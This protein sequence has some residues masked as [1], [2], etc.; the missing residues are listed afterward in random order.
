MFDEVGVRIY[1]VEIENPTLKDLRSDEAS[2]N[3]LNDD[4][5]KLD[6]MLEIE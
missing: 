5:I 4:L 2:K 1:S 6:I 3:E